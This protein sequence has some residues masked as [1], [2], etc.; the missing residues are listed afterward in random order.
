[1]RLDSLTG[2][3]RAVAAVGPV[4]G[5]AVEPRHLELRQPLRRGHVAVQP[6]HDHPHREAVQLRQ[7]RRRSCRR[8]AASRASRPAAPRA[9][10][11]PR[12]RRRPEDSTMS[13]P[14]FGT[15][16]ASRSRMEVPSQT[17]VPFS[18]P[19]TS[20]ETHISVVGD[21]CIGSFDSSRV[22]Q[23]ERVLDLAGHLH[24]PGG[25]VDRRRRER[26][27]DPV[28]GRVR[29]SRA[30]SA[31]AGRTSRRRQ[32]ARPSRSASGG[33]PG[34]SPAAWCARPCR[35]IARSRPRRPGERRHR[36]RR[37]GTRG[38]PA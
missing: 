4:R 8:R 17:A 33:R 32:E 1:M 28:E 25:R 10:C 30:A 27:V 22:A 12:S 37:R 20:F 31:R 23:R 36:R 35:W 7:R 38:A 3:M 2:A 34:R 19:P 21:S 26:D 6:G 15:A 11:W 13:A 14:A 16:F 9:A 29:W 5:S 24:A 18:V